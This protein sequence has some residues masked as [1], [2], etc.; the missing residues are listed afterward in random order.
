MASPTVFRPANPVPK[1]AQVTQLVDS[2]GL[3]IVNSDAKTATATPQNPYGV[4]ASGTE[5]N[6]RPFDSCGYPYFDL[7]LWSGNATTQPT[8]PA[9]TACA[10]RAFA[11]VPVAHVNT[12]GGVR[13]TP[14]EISS[15]VFDSPEALLT[16]IP[17]P[18]GLYVPLY[19]ASGSNL[20]TFSTSP[21]IVQ[22][23]NSKKFCVFGG[24]SYYTRGA[25]QILVAVSTALVQTSSTNA[26]L[27]A[28]LAS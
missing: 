4:A 25:S 24:I 28:S 14:N 7:F 13:G 11:L 8:D 17:A 1:H 27:L 9:T 5:T 6:V 18:V 12:N 20:Q 2:T 23:T 15:T 10:V 26:V 3:F 16:G 21:D 19:S 22:S